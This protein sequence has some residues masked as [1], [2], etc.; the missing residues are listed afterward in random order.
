VAIRIC[1]T[2]SGG[3]APYEGGGERVLNHGTDASPAA[4]LR[5]LLKSDDRMIGVS[6]QWGQ[7]ASS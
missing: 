3:L 6:S 4:P 1:G 5:M 2:R 7:A